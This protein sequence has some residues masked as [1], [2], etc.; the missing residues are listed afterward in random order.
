MKICK[1]VFIFGGLFFVVLLIISQFYQPLTIDVR[2]IDAVQIMSQSG[3]IES[4]K[5]WV[6]T[7]SDYNY[8]KSV[9]NI[10]ELNDLLIR[11]NKHSSILNVSTK[12]MESDLN[13]KENLPLSMEVEGLSVISVPSVYTTD[14]EFR[15]N[16]SNTLARLIDYAKGDIVLDLTN[17]SGGDVVPMIIGASSLIPAGKILNSIDKNGN[18]FPIYLDSNKLFG[19]ITNYLENSSKQLQTK[20]YPFKKNKKVSVIISDRTASA[21]EVLTLIL[22]KNPNVTVLG[23]PSAGYTS[24]NETAIL[25]NKDNPSN[26]W[27]MIYTA[28]YFE[29]IKNREVFNN[30]K[31]FPDVEVRSAYLDITNRQLIK[32]IKRINKGEQGT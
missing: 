29:T 32:A 25:P 31:I 18:K 14:N 3:I 15:S 5:K 8:G 22:K 4:K 16:Y 12:N 2:S 30:T 28:G 13:I 24:W 19:G 27:Y 6:S 17:N 23:T 9:K 10:S 11:G 20:K 7:L 21:A 26:F 1:Y